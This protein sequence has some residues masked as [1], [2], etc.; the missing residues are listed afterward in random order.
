M[1]TFS[2]TAN[3][4]CCRRYEISPGIDKVNSTDGRTDFVGTLPSFVFLA[5]AV[6]KGNFLPLLSVHLSIFL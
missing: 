3:Y 1:K 6:S 4:R 2:L 5:I